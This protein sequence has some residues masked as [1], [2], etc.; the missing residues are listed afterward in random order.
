M[1]IRALTCGL[2]L[3]S[4]DFLDEATLRSKIQT[5]YEAINKVESDLFAAFDYIP[6]TKRISLN[7]FEIW[8][9]LNSIDICIAYLTT[10]HGILSDLN[11][12]FCSL[13]CATSP[14]GMACIAQFLTISP[15]FYS[16]SLVHQLEAVP[17]MNSCRCAAQTLLAVSKVSPDGLRC[18]GYGASFNC[19]PNIPYFP[20]SYHSEN[21]P[22]TLSVGMECGDLLFIAFHGVTNHDT[23]YRNLRDILLQIFQPLDTALRKS[24]EAN[25]LIYGGIDASIN[26]GLSLPDSV[27]NGIE[28]LLPNK[29]HFGSRGTLSVISVVTKAIKSLKEDNI[30]L[31]GYSGIMLPVMEDLILS[32]RA[33]TTPPTFTI[34]DLLLYSTVCGVGLDV[35]PVSG[36]VTVDEIANL[37]VDL[38]TLALRLN[39]PLSC[40]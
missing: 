18:F 12:D 33:A 26:P 22:P 30:L 2:S 31:C 6:Q 40:R 17:D 29:Q 15:K 16:S 4:E 24:C 23:A 19:P 13:G 34:K 3:T 7:S 32:A 39:K 14:L 8:L 28:Q 35:I 37:Y 27:G 21:V 9:P 20:A 38:G 25:S 36:N 11:I 5:C 10:L 1:K